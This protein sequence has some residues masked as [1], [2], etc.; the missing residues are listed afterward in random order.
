[1]S[2]YRDFDLMDIDANG[3]WTNENDPTAIDIALRHARIRPSLQPRHSRPNPRPLTRTSLPTARSTSTSSPAGNPISLPTQQPIP[4]TTSPHHANPS[5]GATRRAEPARPGV[6]G[7]AST[8]RRSQSLRPASARL[9]RRRGAR[10]RGCWAWSP[11]WRC[12][13]RLGY[14]GVFSA[15]T[16]S[17]SDGR[18]AP[19]RSAQGHAAD[20]R[21][22]ARQPRKLRHRRR[23]LRGQRQPD[24][25]H[26]P[27][28]RGDQGQ[29]GRHRLQVRLVRNRQE[30]RP[31][32][33]QGQAGRRPRS[34]PPS[35]S[36]RSS[37]TRAKATSSPPR[38]R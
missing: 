28:P 15:W 12:S 4:S 17:S 11:A 1:M 10:R 38:S 9:R 8:T 14:F 26:Q 16:G 27:R 25:D 33:H 2:L 36:W 21:H 3:V 37:A 18:A 34:R 30:H 31:A 7:P 35:R 6:P 13:A 22:R 29:E 32:G 20:H 23:H 19:V 5:S 24:Q